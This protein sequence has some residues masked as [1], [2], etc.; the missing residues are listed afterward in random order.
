[1]SFYAGG[2]LGED[3]EFQFYNAVHFTCDH[4]EC[5]E[6]TEPVAPVGISGLT[7]TFQEV[8]PGGEEQAARLARAQGW[9]I[10]IDQSFCP[11]HRE[12]EECLVDI[13]LESSPYEEAPAGATDLPRLKPV[14][15][16]PPPLLFLVVVLTLISV[17]C[18]LACAHLS[19][20]VSSLRLTLT[21]DNERDFERNSNVQPISCTSLFATPR[22]CS[23]RMTIEGQP[24][25]PVRYDCD[26]ERCRFEK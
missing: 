2:V 22:S 24:D 6:R 16:A 12:E 14:E 8:D 26:A 4:P 10:R 9:L 17:V 11:K 19:S 20:E 5:G 7:I 18:L 21:M 15:T 23:G 13:E 3:A 1:M 25:V